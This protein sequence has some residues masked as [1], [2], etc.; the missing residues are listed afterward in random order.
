MLQDKHIISLNFDEM[1][2]NILQRLKLEL[3]KTLTYHDINHTLS[4]EKASIRLCEMENFSELDTLIMR[5]AILYHDAGFIHQYTNNEIFAKDMVREDLPKYG[6][7]DE[8]IEAIIAI[9]HSTES[10]VPSSSVFDNI[11]SDSDHD[12]FGRPDYYKVANYLREE[13]AVF[14]REFDELEWIDFQLAYLDGRHKF[15]TDSAKQLRDAE[16]AKR[17]EELK[18]KRTTLES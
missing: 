2:E 1:R 11:M 16:K 14:G 10:G 8:Q 5:T 4:V 9:I 3:P 17:I 18:A 13:L 6:Y 15:L 12:Y 7:S